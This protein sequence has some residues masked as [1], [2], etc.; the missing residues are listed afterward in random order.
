MPPN[1]DVVRQHAQA[2][3]ER[4][5]RVRGTRAVLVVAVLA[6]IALSTS[7][8]CYAVLNDPVALAGYRTPAPVGQLFEA[9]APANVVAAVR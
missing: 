7:M 6:L 4:V 1:L 8:M 3:F 9:G 5:L 2:W